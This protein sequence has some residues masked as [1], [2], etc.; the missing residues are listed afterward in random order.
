MRPTAE[1]IKLSIERTVLRD[2][3]AVLRHGHRRRQKLI[4]KLRDLTTA[5]LVAELEMVRQRKQRK[6]A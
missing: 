5:Q 1:I 6:A 3:I 4:N 2:S